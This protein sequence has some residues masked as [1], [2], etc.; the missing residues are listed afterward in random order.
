MKTQYQNPIL[1]GYADPDVYFENGVYYLYATSY[2]YDVWT[3]TDLVNWEKKPNTAITAP[4][5]GYDEWHWAPDV[6][7]LPDG[8]YLMAASVREHLGLLTATSPERK[9]RRVVS[10]PYSFSESRVPR[11]CITSSSDTAPVTSRVS[12]S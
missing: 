2:R 3:S 7:R 8:R 9:M 10:S 6:K 5:W 11:R 12:T 4:V 1:P